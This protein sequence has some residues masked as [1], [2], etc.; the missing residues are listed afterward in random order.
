MLKSSMHVIFVCGSASAC[1]S[2]LREIFRFRIFLTHLYGQT[3]LLLD[4]QEVDLSYANMCVTKIQSVLL[5]KLAVSCFTD[6]RGLAL[7]RR[8]AGAGDKSP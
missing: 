1:K 2:W 7:C 4:A 8:L 3:D 5:N 6:D